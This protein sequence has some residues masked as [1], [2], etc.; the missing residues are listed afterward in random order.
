MA[1]GLLVVAFAGVA[2]GR[3]AAE[4]A[5]PAAPTGLPCPPVIT[6]N[7]AGALVG[8][9]AKQ[10]ARATL[11]GMVGWVADGAKAAL[12]RIASLSSETTKVHVAEPW[13]E[14]RVGKMR[15]LAIW[16]VLPLLLAALISAVVHQDASRLV[17][18]VGVHLPLAVLGMFVVTQ[19]TII[20]LAITDELC[21]QISDGIGTQ[22][23]QTFQDLGHAMTSLSTPIN[24][25]TGGVLALLAAAL[26]VIGALVIWMELLLRS[27]AISVA[28]MFLPLTL[29]G[30]VWPATARWAKRMVE[31]L[32][33]LILSKFVIVA[34]IS[35]GVAG[36]HSGV[37]Q[38]DLGA[39]LTGAA[40]LLLAAFAPFV[41]LRLMPLVEAGV[42][43]HLEGV[44]RRP[45]SA[46]MTSHELVH[47]MVQRH[48]GGSSRGPSESETATAAAP[49]PAPGPGFA[50]GTPG[51]MD[52]LVAAGTDGE[53]S[54]GE[55]G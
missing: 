3:A 28:V 12:D 43:G 18:A 1:A 4:P 41:L 31:I 50:L 54:G 34:V 6:C 53:A 55:R 7:P 23:S 36:L 14:D 40:M 27:T 19:L 49:D 47:R 29:A 17:R 8:D 48:D 51:F 46:A 44:S 35:L 5:A 13:V 45:V 15:E 16:L 2:V 26:M 33:A 37:K 25:G 22:P 21:A 10:A 42:I 9:A 32:L 52:D 38:D 11:D 24:P 20:G 39:G 30:L